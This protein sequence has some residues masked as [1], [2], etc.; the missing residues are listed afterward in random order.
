VVE[1]PRLRRPQEV[2]SEREVASH[3]PQFHC[4]PLLFGVESHRRIGQRAV[5]CEQQ[6]SITERTPPIHGDESLHGGRVGP[7]ASS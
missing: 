1:I 4:E 5:A 3:L 2:A 6:R 7:H